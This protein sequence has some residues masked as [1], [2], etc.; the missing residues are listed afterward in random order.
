MLDFNYEELEN[1]LLQARQ[2][3]DT[4]SREWDN[5]RMEMEEKIKDLELELEDLRFEL[6][7][8]D[9]YPFTL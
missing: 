6:D 1:A 8:T 7:S 3:L 2:E 5:K 4:R 9:W